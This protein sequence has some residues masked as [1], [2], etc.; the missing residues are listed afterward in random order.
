MNKNN[1]VVFLDRDGTINVDKHYLYKPE[2][3]ELLPGVVDGLKR[4][5]EFGYMLIIIT[6]Q[7]GIARGYYTE[8]EFHIL[9]Q[10]MKELLEQHGIHIT[11]VLYCPH[12]PSA[13]VEKYRMT[14][15]CRKPKLGLFFEAIR[16]WDI[17][18]NKSWAIG[19]KERDVTICEETSCRG[20]ILTNEHYPT[21]KN[22]ILVKDFKKAVDIILSEDRNDQYEDEFSYTV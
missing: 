5:Q 19:D 13:K 8:Q 21:K 15:C 3:F 2:E 1:K 7:S 17:D 10:Y 22:I 18:L 12:L 16:K 4:L 6:N 20:I 14:C 11:D 9:N